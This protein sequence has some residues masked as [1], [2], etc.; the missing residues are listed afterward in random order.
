MVM[1]ATR[2]EALWCLVVEA[3][4]DSLSSSGCS[5]EVAGPFGVVV[6]KYI[7]RRWGVFSRFIKHEVGDGSKI[8]FWH[9]VWCGDQPLKEAFPKLFSIASCKEAWV[10]DKMQISNGLFSGMSLL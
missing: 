2:R 5:K 1:E 9:N 3:K 7:L 6:L 10:V 4:Y 8:R